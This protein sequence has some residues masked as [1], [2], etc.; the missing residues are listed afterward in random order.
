MTYKGWARVAASQAWGGGAGQAHAQLILSLVALF[1][2]IMRANPSHSSRIPGPAAVR[3]TSPPSS[4]G[5]V[6]VLSPTSTCTCKYTSGN[7]DIIGESL[8]VYVI[9]QH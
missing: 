8:S 2:A 3:I 6:S 7:A 9:M 4:H 5:P 1:C